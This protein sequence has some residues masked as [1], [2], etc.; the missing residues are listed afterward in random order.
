MLR[1]GL[2][3]PL[4]GSRRGGGNIGILGGEENVNGGSTAWFVSLFA[5]ALVV[6]SP[7]PGPRVLSLCARG[8]WTIN[9]FAYGGGGSS[10]MFPLSGIHLI[11]Y[12]ISNDPVI[13]V[14]PLLP[15]PDDHARLSTVTACLP[16]KL[17]VVLNGYIVPSMK[18]MALPDPMREIETLAVP[19]DVCVSSHSPAWQ[20][21]AV[22]AA[23]KPTK[24]AAKAGAIRLSPAKARPLQ[25][26]GVSG[27]VAQGV[28][29]D[30]SVQTRVAPAPLLT[31]FRMPAPLPFPSA[32]RFLIPLV[33][34]AE[35]RYKQELVPMGVLYCRPMAFGKSY[36][37]RK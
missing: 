14:V 26:S 30:V 21:L 24:K 17:M 23:I 13:E 20:G 37:L 27:S 32:N 7:A 36:K 5:S 19:V 11:R 35:G 33:L 1:F 28:A 25:V 34:S 3:I 12:V 4:T 22:V 15:L 29:P 16:A 31:Q 18:A 9:R 8:L 2:Q 10:I 6:P